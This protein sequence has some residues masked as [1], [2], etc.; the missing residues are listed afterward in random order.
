MMYGLCEKKHIDYLALLASHIEML[1]EQGNEIIIFPHSVRINTQSTHNNDLPVIEKLIKIIPSHIQFTL[2]EKD[3]SA[4]ELRALIEGCDL[5]V[6]SRFHALISALAVKTPVLVLGWSHKY[7]E[8][9]KQFGLERYALT[10]DNM[11]IKKLNNLYSLMKD[12]E[13]EIKL[14]VE[15]ALGVTVE[16]C[17]EFYSELAPS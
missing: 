16:Q 14:D 4:A 13:K 10:F 6:A 5:L 1:F 17:Q 9:L 11:E 3:L 7:R 2:V 15:K 12:K 8:V